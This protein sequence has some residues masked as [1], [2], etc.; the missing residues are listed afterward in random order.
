MCCRAFAPIRDR[1]NA[2]AKATGVTYGCGRGW[3]RAR[4]RATVRHAR[5]GMGAMAAQV[6]EVGGAP[7]GSPGGLAARPAPPT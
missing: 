3:S 5:V 1:D 6:L 7:T 2:L 4:S